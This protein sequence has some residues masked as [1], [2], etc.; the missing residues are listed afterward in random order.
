MLVEIKAFTV[1]FSLLHLVHHL[2]SYTPPS[3]NLSKSISTGR[4]LKSS[5]APATGVTFVGERSGVRVGK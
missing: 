5:S 1:L 4:S 2:R 3:R